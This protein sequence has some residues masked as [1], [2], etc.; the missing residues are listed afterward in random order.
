MRVAGSHEVAKFQVSPAIVVEDLEDILLKHGFFLANF[1]KLFEVLFQKFFR[2]LYW[3]GLH[4]FDLNLLNFSFSTETGNDVFNGLVVGQHLLMVTST[5]CGI[6]GLDI[7]AHKDID[8]HESLVFS[9]LLKESHIFTKELD[10]LAVLLRLPM[11]LLRFLATVVLQT[12]VVLLLA[13]GG[14][15]EAVEGEITTVEDEGVLDEGGEV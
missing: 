10:I 6:L 4:F 3:N 13:D 9:I 11:L 7:V 15:P 8:L 14:S 2:G 12:R 5:L 1:L